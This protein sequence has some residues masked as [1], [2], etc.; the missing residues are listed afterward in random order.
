MDSLHFA[1]AEK[2]GVNILLTVD[3]PQHYIIHGGTKCRKNIIYGKVDRYRGHLRVF[4]SRLFA[5]NIRLHAES[6][7]F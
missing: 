5:Y 4:K 1:S 2:G 7:A 6:I 3:I